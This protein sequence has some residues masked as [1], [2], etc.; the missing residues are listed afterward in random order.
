MYVLSLYAPGQV[1]IDGSVILLDIVLTVELAPKLPFR[2][3]EARSTGSIFQH[4]DTEG[5]TTRSGD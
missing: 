4:D 1:E 2:A 5:Q 3:A